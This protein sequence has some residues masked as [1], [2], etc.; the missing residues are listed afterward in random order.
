M[1]HTLHPLGYISLALLWDCVFG[2][3]GYL[4]LRKSHHT[5]LSRDPV[6]V[7]FYLPDN[8]TATTSNIS[9]SLLKTDNNQK[10]TS[11]EL[12][13]NTSQG[14]LLFE[15]FY[16]VE[17]G[18][19]QFHMSLQ[20]E[21]SS[22][23]RWRSGILNV[24]WPTFHLDL[25]RTSKDVVR[26]FQ[27]G[28]FT[29]ER[30][31]STLPKKDPVI[32]LEVE[33]T[34][35]FQEL[36]EPSSD[37][38]MLYKTYKDIPLISSQWVEFE[39]ASVRPETFITV[40][41]KPMFSDSVIAYLGPIDLVK[42]FKYKLLTTTEPKCDS[43]VN[44]YVVPPPCNYVEG[45][46]VVY[47]ESPRI[48]SEGIPPVAESIMQTGDKVARFNC[49]LF[50]IGKNK[51]CF[52]FLTYSS[53]SLPK[54]KECVD[55][56]REIETWS[57]WQPWSPC[58]TTCGD[59]QRERHREC[60]TTSLIKPSCNGSPKETSMCSLEDC[61]TA[62]PSSKSTK[63]SKA[64]GNTSNT[65][66]ITG[67][68][69]CLF[70]IVITVVITV[71]RKLGK[72][73]KCSPTARHSSA[74]SANCRKNSDE[75]NICQLR[76]SFSET[77]EILDSTE[78]IVNI[79]LNYRQSLPVAEEQAATEI[80]SSQNVQKIIPPIF[81]YR[82]AQQQLK[83]MRQKGLTE[84]TKLYHVSPNPM[85]DTAVD[86]ATTTALA[87][88]NAEDTTAN[89]FRIQSPFLE[90]KNNLGRSYGERPN[91]KSTFL[92][93]QGMSPSQTLPRL[94]PVKNQDAKARHYERAHQKSNHFRRTSSFHETKHNKPYRERSLTTLSPRQ[95]MAYNPKTRTWEYYTVERSKHKGIRADKSPENLTRGNNLTIDSTGYPSKYIRSGE[96]KPD[97]ISNRPLAATASNVERPGATRPRK[98][99]S[100][101]NKSW[102]RGQRNFSASP[103][104]IYNRHSSLSPAQDR[105]EKCQSFPWAAEYSYYDN[106]TFGLTEAEQEML[107]LPGYFA[108][109]EEDETSTLSVERL[110]I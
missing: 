54:A 108:S 110:V 72:S 87:T 14:G 4:L 3:P 70:I 97:L 96:S 10:I 49:S 56:R 44:V 95:S 20:T 31:C 100:P 106:L 46:L 61:S 15:C 41:L 36:E 76:E 89:K 98:G 73:Q 55:I 79:P 75:E 69:L 5:A 43:L 47:K 35:S 57:L 6:Y 30:L 51:Y 78:E 107:D 50:E 62:K 82:L 86:I 38:F 53:K 68:S 23:I 93:S 83:E 27:I 32:L 1:K 7:D 77:G 101:V 80:D 13:A 67:I 81:S 90:Q 42:T 39:C 2:E 71:W 37:R 48:L 40:A 34:H 84:T 21:N 65:V 52:E 45:K 92:L 66:T 17:A 103:N 94:S 26:S 102:N 91:L 105:R 28:V 24:T 64:D 63:N 104:E 33:H 59:G 60:L 99:P 11:K 16:F 9:I 18:L 88:D 109:N 19:Y 74:H 12:P 58:S 8:D 22:R 29:N 85:A 25:N